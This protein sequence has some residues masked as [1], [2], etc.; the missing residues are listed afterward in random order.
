MWNEET[1]PP[2]NSFLFPYVQS[3]Y[4]Y[5]FDFKRLPGALRVDAAERVTSPVLHSHPSTMSADEL[6]LHH[7]NLTFCDCCTS[8][9]FEKSECLMAPR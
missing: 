5:R 1:V 2:P 9:F 6:N 4:V 8:R 7:N 3:S